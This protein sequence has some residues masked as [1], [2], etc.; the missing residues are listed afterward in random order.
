MLSVAE[1]LELETPV[2]NTLSDNLE[3]ILTRL[4]RTGNLKVFLD[5]IGLK[6][7]VSQDIAPIHSKEGKIIVIGDSMA[8]KNTLEMVAGKLGI[9]RARF[10]FCLDY[11][12]AKTFNFRKTQWSSAYCAIMVG[13]TPHS[14][15]AKETYGSILA[16][17][18]QKE[19]YPPV[20]RIGARSDTLKISKTSFREALEYMLQK[21]IIQ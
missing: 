16:A 6:C 10:E 20:I 12:A 15:K 2:R 5:M 8:P 1:L 14:G 18:E 19:G 3:E 21:S 7:L 9:D 17:L 13:P 11:E 4:N